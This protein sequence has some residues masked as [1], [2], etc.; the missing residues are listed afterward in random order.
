MLDSYKLSREHILSNPIKEMKRI[1]KYQIDYLYDL[2]ADREFDALLNGESFVKAPRIFGEK[3][4]D[5]VHYKVNVETICKEDRFECGDELYYDGNYWLCLEASVFHDL[6]CHGVF[7]KCNQEIFWL[8]KNRKLQSQHCI[9]INTTQYNSG[10]CADRYMTLGSA[11]HMLRMQCNEKTLDLRSPIRLFLDKNIENPICHKVTQ[12][13]NSSYN[14]GKG[15]CAVTVMEYGTNTE[16][17]KLI[18]LDDG[19][20]IWIADWM[21]N[22]ECL[23]DNL[24]K[25]T[26]TSE[27]VSKFQTI[28]IGK[29]ATF[30]ARFKDNNGNIIEDIAPVWNVEKAFENSINIEETDSKIVIKVEDKS[31]ENQTIILSLSASDGSVSTTSITLPIKS[32]I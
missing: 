8:D 20:K 19:R 12:N 26:I 3:N 23:I 1:K 6:Y 16:R 15:L 7:Q 11:Q 9:D 21:E 10:E 18:T 17:D 22:G 2:A 4:K 32:L 30:E 5:E 25:K 29:T 13:D 31:L 14:F 27:I 28:F 24:E